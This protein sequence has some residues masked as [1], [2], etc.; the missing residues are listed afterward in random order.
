MEPYTFIYSLFAVV[1]FAVLMGLDDK[2]MGEFGWTRPESLAC[3]MLWPVA[4]IIIMIIGVR[5]L[6]RRLRGNSIPEAR[7]L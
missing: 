2:L 1:S 6:W 5:R 4:M 7:L 3:S